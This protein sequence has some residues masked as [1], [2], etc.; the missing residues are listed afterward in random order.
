MPPASAEKR[1]T[2]NSTPSQ[3]CQGVESENMTK[4]ELSQYYWLKHEIDAYERR[5]KEI[6]SRAESPKAMNLSGMPG[7]HEARDS[8]G[9]VVAE[10][11]DLEAIIAAKRIQ[12]IHERQRIERYVMGIPDSMTRT[13]FTC[14]CIEGM[15]WRE[16]AAHM[17][18]RMSESNA[19]QIFHRWLKMDS[20][21]KGEAET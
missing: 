11:T 8:V 2:Y 6:R 7:S 15:T 19:K 18:H 10:I 5:L 16:V 14:R 17:G 13:V 21:G 12:C 1:H 4:K 3:G 20:A 9:E